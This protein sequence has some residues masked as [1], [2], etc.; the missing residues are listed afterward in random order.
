MSHGLSVRKPM[1]AAINGG[2]AGIGFMQALVCDLRFAA[3]GA[4]LATAFAQRGLPA[5]FGASWL[6]VRLVGQGHALD[7]LLSGRAVSAEEA[8]EMGLVQRVLAPEDLV[9]AARD[10]RSLAASCSPS[11]MATIKAQVAA[12]WT[13]SHAE[14]FEDARALVVDPRRRVDFAEGVAS[15]AERRAPRFGPLPARKDWS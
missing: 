5:E 9:P 13:R 12:D 15:Y 11:A 14:S 10:A 7:L 6:L 8:L 4:K 3:R 1:I 2:C